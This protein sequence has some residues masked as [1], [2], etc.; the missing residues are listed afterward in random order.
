[1]VATT[2]LETILGDTA[3]AV[4]PGDPRYSNL[5]GQRVRHP[6]LLGTTLPV[7]GDEAVNP[8]LG[9]GTAMFSFFCY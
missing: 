1:V 9:T 3:V 7:V 8:E 6:F 5:I 4:N 2:R